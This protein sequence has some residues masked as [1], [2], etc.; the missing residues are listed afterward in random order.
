ME[1]AAHEA[2]HR[3][4]HAAAPGRDVA[5]RDGSGGGSS[6]TELSTSTSPATFGVA[7]RAHIGERV[8]HAERPAH[9]Q[10]R[11][12]LQIGDQFGDVL[13]A[14]A[15]LVARAGTS[16]SPWPRGSNATT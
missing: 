15:R 6:P 2:V 5:G 10:H 11:H 1:H 4:S 16:D 14:P 8:E 7:M 9:Q 12:R 13:P 3:D